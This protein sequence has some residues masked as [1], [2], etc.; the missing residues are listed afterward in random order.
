MTGAQGSRLG[1]MFGP[2]YLKR[3]LGRGGMGEVYEAEHTVKKWTVAVKLMSVAFSQDPVFRKRMEREARITGR[4]LE[5][6]VV[7]IHDYGEIDGQLYLE[8]R[9]I[10]GIDLGSL[11]ERDGPLPAPRAVAIIHQIASALDAAHAAGVT[12]RDVKPQ[13]I[14]ITGNDFAYLVDFGIASAKTDEKLTQLGTAVGTWKYMAPERFS[15]NEVTP[16]A[17]VYALACVLYECLTGEPPY[18]ADTAAMLVTSHM[19]EPIPRPSAEGLGVDQA[20]DN[21]IAVGMAKDPI[22]RYASAGDLAESAHD[23][24]S[25]PER[26]RAATIL[27]RSDTSARPQFTQ[28]GGPPPPLTAPGIVGPDQPGTPRR[29]NLW[30]ILVTAG[31]VV[32]V[33]IAV[34]GIWLTVKPAGQQA[35]KAGGV[36]T[37]VPSSQAPNNDQARLF[38]LLPQGYLAGTCTPATPESGSIWTSAV[39][40]V[41]CGQNTQPGGPSHATYGLFPT[42]NRLKKAFTDDIGNVSLVNCP[43]E[44]AS[45]V[46]WHYDQT[47]NEMAGLVACGHYNG[48]PIVIW[49]NEEKLMLSDV[50]GDPATVEDLHTWWDAYG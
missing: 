20:F 25:R 46:S 44:E 1:T 22:E 10:E 50:A 19:M 8:M 9:L 16:R 15:E 27:R 24:L 6:H 39:A 36:K 13:N 2:Y 31:V 26:D 14:L 38:S 12:H 33:V 35:S 18:R 23:A 40:L 7:P 17:D 28:P 5:P 47:P 49:T 42:P 29:R 43:G 4:L 34:V 21:V 41:T 32:V 3:L 30:P 37:P 48:H 11:L 45:P